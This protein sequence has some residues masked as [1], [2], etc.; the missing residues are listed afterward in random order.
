MGNL[1]E[2]G[3]VPKSGHIGSLP[4]KINLD[5]SKYKKKSGVF[6]Y[7]LN[8]EEEEEDRSIF[9]GILKILKIIL[10]FWVPFIILLLIIEFILDPVVEG[11][12]FRDL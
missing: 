3:G 1:D 8:L 10:W 9:F 2:E 11:L 12:L 6:F 7:S 4:K 5:D